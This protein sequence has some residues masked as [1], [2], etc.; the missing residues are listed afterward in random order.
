MRR[1]LIT[2]LCLVITGLL[3]WL[4]PAL[5]EG[6]PIRRDGAIRQKDW[7]GTLR[8]WVCQD[9]SS[10]FSAWLMEQAAAFE[11]QHSGTHVRIQRVQPGAWETPGAVLPDVL[12]F[13]PGSL[14][15][16]QDYLRPFEGTSDFIEEAARSGR[17]MARQYALPVALG[18]YVALVNEALYPASGTLSDPGVLKKTQRYAIGAPYSGGVAALLGW[19]RG[20]S[21]ARS[22]P[23]PDGF[24]ASTADAMYAKFT[25]GSIAALICPIDYARKF[26]AL[27]SVGRGFAYRVETPLLPF[28]DMIIH[29]GRFKNNAPRGADEKANQ[30]TLYLLSHQAQ[31]KLQNYGLIPARLDTVPTSSAPVICELHSQYINRL[32]IPNT[33]GWGEARERFLNEALHALRNGGDAS[34]AIERIR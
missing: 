3:I 15:N 29:I 34:E 17:W 7:Q 23:L 13:A 30:L 10:G 27:E 2:I 22:L 12:L 8:V 9:W 1:K 11:K 25:Q 20:I 6:Y 32:V 14:G 19:E 5:I 16:P 26:A 31:S 4:I 21:A 33:F 28:T 24:G 18:G